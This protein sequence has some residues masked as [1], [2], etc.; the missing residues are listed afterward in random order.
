MPLMASGGNHLREK[1]DMEA[2]RLMISSVDNHIQRFLSDDEAR[3][4]LQGRCSARL[5]AAKRRG[6][7]E[8]SEDS[9][10]SNLYWGVQNVEAAMKASALEEWQLRLVSSERMLQ[11]PAMLEEDGSTAGISNRYIVC[12]AYFYLSLV[13]RLQGDQWQMAIHMLQAVIVSPRFVRVEFAPG[14]SGNLFMP[15]IGGGGCEDAVDE[16]TGKLARRYKDWLMYYRVLSYGDSSLP[17]SEDPCCRDLHTFTDS[18]DRFSVPAEQEDLT[19]VLHKFMVN[20]PRYDP[21]ENH[22]ERNLPT[23]R[24]FMGGGIVSGRKDDLNLFIKLDY[25]IYEENK[26]DFDIKQLQEMLADSQSDSASCSN[27]ESDLELRMREE[28]KATNQELVPAREAKQKLEWKP[29]YHLVSG[30]SL[31]LSVLDIRDGAGACS[32]SYDHYLDYS[33]PPSRSPARDV[34]CFGQLPAR[35]LRRKKLNFLSINKDYG[36]ENRIEFLGR[37][38]KAVST[39]FFSQGLGKSEEAGLEVTSVW[40]MLTKNKLSAAKYGSLK[41]GI[42]HQLLDI[43]SS[44]KE[45]RLVRTSVYILLMLISEDRSVIEDIKRNDLHLCCLARALKTNVQEAVIVIYLLKP[46]PSE[47]RDLELL[48]ALVEVACNPR[49]SYK[50]AT[51]SLPLSPTAAS[52]SMIEILVTA[53]DY[54]TNNL[55]LAAISSPQILSKLIN[56][57]NNRNLEEGVALAA[58]LVRCMRLSGNCRKFLSQV[59]PVDPFLHLLRCS[60]LRAKYAALEYFHEILRMPR[61]SAILLLHQIR[62][63]GNINIMHSLMACLKQARFEH[64]LLAANV[65]LQLDMLEDSLGKSVF[66][67]EAMETLLEAL[68]S[69]ETASTHV[70]SG[71]ILSNLGGT[72]AWTGEPYTAAWLVKKGGLSSNTHRN[73]IKNVDWGDP[74]LQEAEIEAWS[75][76]V[77]RSLIGLGSCVFKALAK[78]IQSKTRSVSR[79]C[80]VTITCLGFEMASAGLRSNPRPSAGDALL[81]GV[82]KFLHPGWELDERVLACQCVYNYA[83]GKGIQRVMDFSESLRESFRRLSGVTWMAEELLR[84]TDYLLPTKANVSCVHSQILEAGGAGNGAATALIFYRGLLFAGYA[85][86]SI[87]AWEIK[88][89]TAKLLLEV[90]EHKKAVNCF[91]LSEPGNLLSGSADRTIRV[92]QMVRRRLECLDTIDMKSPVQRIESYGNMIFAITQSRGLK[93]YRSSKTTQTLCKNKYLKC[94]AISQGKIYTGCGDSSIL[95][96]DVVDGRTEEIK[97]AA[98]RWAING[99]PVNSLVFYKGWVYHGSNGIEGSKFKEW[100]RRGKTEAKITMARRG[101][102]QEMS[103]IEDFIYLISTSSPATLQIWLRGQQRKV[104]RLSAGCKISSLLT[105]NDIVLCGTESGLIKGW[106]PL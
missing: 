83:S 53:F 34:R 20:L 86:G 74:C 41:Q 88:G 10:L 55:H 58:V 59:T 63:Q 65:L 14:L 39:V 70:L 45:E 31:S 21:A 46:T 62:Q 3:A 29:S 16:A 2:V 79:D 77:A 105:A 56:V 9:V 49:P 52:I 95:E 90:R 13:R 93:V 23:I 57:A 99:K 91:A 42:L 94:I 101:A 85:D 67:E 72:Y 25:G 40:E 12:C 18:L 28:V 104:G 69:E 54:V 1:L 61:S 102:V 15:R 8:Y 30:K 92:W 103:V 96:I 19:Q 82:L 33:T 84:V 36:A 17:A 97:P 80:L 73:M 98:S 5:A 106:I 27:E 7:F 51:L 75:S 26:E 44:S 22:S 47:I 89:Q 78:G 38:E 66:K 68:E 50:Q 6:H 37:F 11:I 100:R 81:H 48:P 71:F 32:T 43:I 24:D 87:K 4:E 60:E 76:K 35:L 64:K